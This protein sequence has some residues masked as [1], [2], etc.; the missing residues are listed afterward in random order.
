MTNKIISWIELKNT[1]WLKKNG[2]FPRH[3]VT[4]CQGCDSQHCHWLKKV[5]NK[6]AIYSC[7][8]C[9]KDNP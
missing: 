5:N 6:E 4:Y 9:Y 8:N 7:V 2:N 1:R 3:L